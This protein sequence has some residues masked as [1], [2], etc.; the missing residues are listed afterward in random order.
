MVVGFGL[1]EIRSRVDRM[2][3]SVVRLSDQL[4]VDRNK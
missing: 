1:I 4:F 2:D 3:K